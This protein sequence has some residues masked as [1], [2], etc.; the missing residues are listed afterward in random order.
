[1]FWCC[2]LEFHYFTLISLCTYQCQ[3]LIPLLSGQLRSQEDLS[4]RPELAPFSR[5]GFPFTLPEAERPGSQYKFVE[6]KFMDLDGC[7]KNIFKQSQEPPAPLT[8]CLGAPYRRSQLNPWMAVR[9]GCMGTAPVALELLHISFRTFTYW[10]FVNPYPL[11]GSPTCLQERRE[12]I[13][14]YQATNQLLFSMPQLYTSHDDRLDDF[15]KALLLIFPESD[16]YE[17]CQN[18]PADQALPDGS[19]VKYKIDIIYW[20]KW[21][22]VP[23]IFVE[24]KLELGKGGN[25]FWQNNHLY[26]SYMKKNMKS[27][28]NGAPVFLL[29][30]CGMTILHLLFPHFWLFIFRNTSWGR[31]GIFWCAWWQYASGCLTT[32]CKPPAWLYWQEYS[33]SCEHSLGITWSDKTNP[34]VC[35]LM[36]V[37]IFLVNGMMLN[38]VITCWTFPNMAHIPWLKLQMCYI[39]GSYI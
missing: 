17:W 14:V 18:M 23:L 37:W 8:Y 20:H 19:P 28:H 16:S 33:R 39:Q 7:L 35:I 10:S 27:H 36:K 21:T 26:Q 4:K 32:R 22:H 34:T 11:P 13:N 9:D 3:Q 31:G 1:M 30:L 38:P 25:P 15:K 2:F 12:I 6:A 5:R 29:Q 24:V